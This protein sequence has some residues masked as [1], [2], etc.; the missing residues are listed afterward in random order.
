MEGEPLPVDVVLPGQLNDVGVGYARAQVLPRASSPLLIAATASARSLSPAADPWWSR[1]ALVMLT[2]S[3]CL[4]SSICAISRTL[5]L[6]VRPS[7]T[8]NPQRHDR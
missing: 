8:A 4:A 5:R 3:A 1:A 2:K 6:G 7:F